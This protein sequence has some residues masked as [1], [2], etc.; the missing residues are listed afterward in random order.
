MRPPI[1]VRRLRAG[2]RE[3]IEEKLRTSEAFT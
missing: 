3:V 1:F 2:E